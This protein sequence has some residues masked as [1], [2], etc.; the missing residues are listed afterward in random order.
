[1]SRFIFP[2]LQV[3]SDQGAASYASLFKHYVDMDHP[4]RTPTSGMEALA[5]ELERRF[6]DMGGTVDVGHKVTTVVQC[7][8]THQALAVDLDPPQNNQTEMIVCAKQIILAV[9]QSALEHIQWK[10]LAMKRA[11]T[12]VCWLT[13]SKI[14]LGFDKPWWRDLGYRLGDTAT[15]QDIEHVYYYGSEEDYD[16]KPNGRHADRNRNSLLLASYA[17]EAN[18]YLWKYLSANNTGLAP[19]KGRENP[20]ANKSEPVVPLGGRTVSEEMVQ[21]ALQQLANLHDVNVG[22]IPAPYTAVA[23]VWPVSWHR[24]R[25]GANA[26]DLIDMIARLDGDEEVFIVGE[27]FSKEQGWVEGGLRLA[28]YVLENHFALQPLP[29]M[30]TSWMKNYAAQHRPK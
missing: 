5:W 4:Y 30:P 26:T 13:A 2:L 25:P 27:A 11:W 19:F 20:F 14:F 21:T 1:M 9:T 23:Q 22:E 28:E 6:R 17:T 7:D 29:G 18:T 12:Q 24:W 15:T 10:P 3:K 8:S 16:S